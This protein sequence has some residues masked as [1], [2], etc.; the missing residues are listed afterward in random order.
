MGERYIH[1]GGRDEVGQRGGHHV[2]FLGPSE[3][4]ELEA[5]SPMM[6]RVGTQGAHREP[7]TRME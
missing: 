6:P 4:A 2:V 5:G 1:R 7:E 3:I